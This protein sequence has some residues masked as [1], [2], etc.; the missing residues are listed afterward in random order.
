MVTRRD[1]VLA[2]FSIFLARNLLAQGRVQPGVSR[3]RGAATINGQAAKQG[4]AVSAGDRV[5]TAPDAEL[6]FVVERDAMLVR[7][8]SSLELARD[9]FRL[10]TGAVLSVFAPRA[11][12]QL[13]TATA[14][15][16]IR[17]TAAYLEAEPERTYVCTCYGEALLEPVGDPA[18]RETVRT[19]HHEQ[20][21]YIL[22]R[23]APKM[24]A[25][26]P[27]INHA[28]AELELLEGLVGR[29]PPFAG[30]GFPRY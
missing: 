25:P 12:K 3:V 2:S 1:V 10:V 11:R 14:T 26:A 17:G 24:V 28:D 23:G 21:R 8:G 7:Q 20:P 30:K 15:I 13:R 4:M 9:G 19:T 27:M 5:V 22:A 18:A 29:E 16:G 6:L